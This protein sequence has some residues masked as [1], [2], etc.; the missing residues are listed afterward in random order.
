MKAVWAALGLSA[1]VPALALAQVGATG[2][3]DASANANVTPTSAALNL[4]AKVVASTTAESAK[5]DKAKGKADQEIA[6]RIAALNAVLAR[7]DAMVKVSDQVKAN[8]KTNVQNEVSGFTQ[9][10]AKIDADADLSTLKTDVQSVTQS[11]RIFM[12][13]IPQARITAAADRMAT[14]I[15]MMGELGTKLQARINSAKAAGSDTAAL[16]AALADLGTKLTSAQG[17]AQTAVGDVISLAPDNGDKTVEASNDAAIKNG[18]DELK[19]GT[20]DLTAAR[21]DIATIIKGLGSLKAS[22]SASTTVAH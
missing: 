3:V 9:L 12:L 22:A 5:A 21:K 11:Y 8:L 19:S 15:N 10:Q 13:V 2:Q 16:E 14:V 4:R 7:V 1:L 20:S 18:K 17:H 6:R